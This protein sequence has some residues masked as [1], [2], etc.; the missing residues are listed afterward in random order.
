MRIAFTIVHN[1]LHHLKH[2][3]QALNILKTCDWWVVVE[4]AA[5][6]NGSTQ[7]CKKFPSHLHKNGA[8]IDGTR[9]FLRDLSKT[10]KN[11]VYI[12]SN[13]FWESK[14]EQVNRAIK[15]VRKLTK[16]CHLWEID[17]DE[18]WTKEAMIAAE[19]ELDSIP[20]KAGAFQADCYVGKNLKAIG[21]WGEARTYG[22]IRLWKWSGED[23]ICHEPPLLEGA[24]K[25]AAMLKPR[26]KHYNYYFEKDVRFKDLWYGG[27]EG[28]LE[29]WELIN[30]MPRQCFPMHISNLVTGA[31]GRTNTAI[32]WDEQPMKLVQIGSH[33]GR[34]SVRE[35]VRNGSYSCLLVEP[36]P[37]PFAELK[38]SY[39]FNKECIFE[40]CAVSSQDGT[41]EMN[42][43]LAD[44]E[45]SNSEH[46]SVNLNHVLR[47]GTLIGE[48]ATKKVKCYTL[49]SL[50][51]KH[52]WDRQEIEH[53]F[54]DTEGHDCEILLSAD[55]KSLNIKNITFETV[56]T[57]G[58]FTRGE[59]FNET[60]DYLESCG[61]YPNARYESATDI[62]VTKR[63]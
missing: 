57:D 11:L 33:A 2:N 8:S 34:D 23:F 30:S 51:R 45:V 20:D 38:K 48:V 7:W 39:A 43:S 13:G 5:H 60:M 10:A 54:I 62:T 15:E 46:S 55:L 42:F 16:K 19:R 3:D 41:I 56:H 28:I 37:I 32:I 52:G 26:F 49:Q 17:A 25:D 63:A 21:D 44:N 29:R 35:L 24:G 40:N 12:P 4:G 9:E 47:H 22:Y 59:T 1:G 50:L 31:W 58:P 27:H 53:L 61:Y 18:Q 14:D 36:N 6:S